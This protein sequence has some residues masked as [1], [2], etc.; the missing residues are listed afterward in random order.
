MFN[1][2]PI[3]EYRLLAHSV[4]FTILLLGLAVAFGFWLY[5]SLIMKNRK[6][7]QHLRKLNEKA[8]GDDLAKKQLERIERKNKRRRTREKDNIITEMLFTMK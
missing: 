1:G 6:K 8:K 4:I 7:R 2:I 3:S 5:V